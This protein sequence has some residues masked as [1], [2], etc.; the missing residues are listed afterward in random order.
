MSSAIPTFFVYITIYVLVLQWRIFPSVVAQQTEAVCSNTTLSW[1]SNSK[2]QSPCVI[3]SYLLVQC[4]ATRPWDVPAI[5]P[6]QHYSGPQSLP[7]ANDCLC[8]SVVYNLMS[9]CGLCQQAPVIVSWPTWSTN[10][11]QH[12]I[13]QGQWTL[14]IPSGTSVPAWAYVTP[15]TMGG[16]FSPTIAQG[17][18]SS[19][20]STSTPT[21]TSSI[22]RPT[23]TG[24]SN[25]APPKVRPL[26][27]GAIAG[28][29]IGSVL[30]AIILGCLGFLL[31]RWWKRRKAVQKPISPGPDHKSP[32]S[33]ALDVPGSGQTPHNDTENSLP[34]VR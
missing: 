5:T 14:A 2:G 33:P 27:G 19:P 29:V 9:A 7:Y 26:S 23:G 11:T 28:V 10:C 3:A 31:F 8:S 6:D 32:L 12:A 1:M 22:P 16:T 15:D 4:S 20:E 24:G 13:P 34:L 18:T 25:V 30:G 21:P 17:F